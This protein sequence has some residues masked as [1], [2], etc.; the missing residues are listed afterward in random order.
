[1]KPALLVIGLALSAA[2]CIIPDRQIEVTN[3]DIQNKHPVRIVEP[4]ELTEDATI[5]CQDAA[6]EANEMTEICPQPGI[7]ALPHFLD[8]LLP[9]S[10]RYAFC[11]C[12]KG[13]RYSKSIVASTLYVEDR[14]DDPK[15]GLDEIYAAIQFDLDPTTRR[16]DQYVRYQSF[17]NPQVSLPLDDQLKYKPVKRPDPNLRLLELGVTDATIDPCN[18][19]G[20]L[21]QPLAPGY[22]TLRLIVSDRPWYTND[23]GQQQPGV[24]DLASGATYDTRT[25]VFHCYGKV[26]GEGASAREIAMAKTC[27]DDC[28][29]EDGV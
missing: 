7:R 13:E 3:E 21:D 8:P 6:N 28:V 15:N 1:M 10:D 29:P 24:P 4:V 22:H 5:A 27:S 2:S 14:D 11:A 26:A 19:V 12:D 25:Y 18:D 16:P 9:T 20:E 23:E 17:V